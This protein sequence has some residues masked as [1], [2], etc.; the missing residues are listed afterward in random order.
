VTFAGPGTTILTGANTYTGGTFVN[1]GGTLQIGN[2]V[3]GSIVAAGGA[4]V[5]TGSTLEFDEATATYAGAITDN[6]T[7]VGLEGTGITDT[8]SGGITGTGGFYADGRGH[9]HL[10]RREQHLFW[11]Y[12]CDGRHT[13]GRSRQH[14]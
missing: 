7:V 5:G 3:T 6:G 4:T 9:N 1:G 8:L 11:R 2:G 13:Q 10:L 14:P 12:T